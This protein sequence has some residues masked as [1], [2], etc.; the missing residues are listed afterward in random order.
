MLHLDFPSV[1]KLNKSKHEFIVFLCLLE[2]PSATSNRIEQAKKKGDLSYVTRDLEVGGCWCWFICWLRGLPF[3]WPS[4]I[5]TKCSASLDIMSEFK[6]GKGGRKQCQWQLNFYQHSFRF[7]RSLPA[8]FPIN[9]INQT[10]ALAAKETRR[11]VLN[12]LIL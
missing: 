3:P 11:Q 6:I 5:V 2:I 1:L 7:S 9:P 4:L 8:D 10:V 12:F